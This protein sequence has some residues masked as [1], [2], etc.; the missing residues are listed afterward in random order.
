MWRSRRIAI[1]R[2]HFSHTRLPA[3]KGRH[4][5]KSERR[6]S[7][8]T[9]AEP[10]RLASFSRRT[11]PGGGNAAT[12]WLSPPWQPAASPVPRPERGCKP[13]SLG[14]NSACRR[15]CTSSHGRRPGISEPHSGRH[16]PCRPIAGRP[17]RRSPMRAT[18][19]AQPPRSRRDKDVS[20]QKLKHPCSP[21]RA[22]KQIVDERGV[23]RKRMCVRL[24]APAP[25][26]H[27]EPLCGTAG[28]RRFSI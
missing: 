19:E 4:A 24:I 2:W 8:A 6:R 23:I 1:E 5:S 9:P 10:I 21:K 26:A 11:P 14:L 28:W 27:M 22:G 25:V 13:G 18:P 12:S 20:L 17:Y 15:P 3:S 16:R 7:H